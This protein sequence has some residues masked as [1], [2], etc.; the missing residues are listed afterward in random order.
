[1]VPN[2]AASGVPADLARDGRAAA[3]RERFGDRGAVHPLGGRPAAAQESDRADPR[4]R[5]AGR[6]YPQ[7]K[8]EPGAGRQGDLVRRAGPRGGAR[9]RRRAT[10]SS[11]AASSPTPTCCSSTTP[12]T[13]SFSRRSTKASACPRWRRWPAAARW[14]ARNTSAL[15]EV[16]DGAAILFDPYAVDEIVRALADLL[17]DARTARAHGAARTAARGALQLAEDR[18]SGRSKFS[19]KSRSSRARHKRASVSA[20]HSSSMNHSVL[21]FPFRCW[22]LCAPRRPAA[23]AR[24]VTGFPVPGRNPALQHQL[25]ERPQPRRRDFHGAQDRR[26]RLELRHARSTPACPGSPIADTL[27]LHRPRADLCSLD[28][29]RNITHGSEEDPREDHVRPEERHGAARDGPAADGGKS[30]FDIPTCAR[31]ALAFL[32]FARREMGQGRVPPA[33]KVFFGSAYDVQ[34]GVH[35]RDEYHGR[36]TSRPSPIT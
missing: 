32:Y 34:H 15:P 3:V 30:D 13:C 14:S 22:P 36:R 20:D 6:A 5:A 7:L 2:A 1:M 23:A 31:D 35:R 24:Q 28:F 8:H 17:L 29:E 10:A 21:V 12:A 9:I 18:A 26:R 11:S 25:A 27:P 16:V 33:Q 19:T 4:L